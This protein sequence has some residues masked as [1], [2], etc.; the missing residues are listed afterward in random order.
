MF[1]STDISVTLWI[2][3]RNKKE[4]TFEVNDGIK[5]YRS[6][7]GEVL[8]IDLRR[9]G[10]PYEKSYVEFIEEDVRKIA[11]NYHNWQQIDWKTTYQNIPE[12]CY[13]ANL[14]EIRN[15]NYSLTPS[16]YVE[17]VDRDLNLDFDIEMKR[18]QKKFKNIIQEE[19]ESQNELI[20]AFKILGYEI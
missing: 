2:L 1:Y 8:F 11:D 12:Y 6:R 9:W 5:N 4:R 16:K 15:N 18:I 17:F 19:K 7:E 13:S 3:N 14:E 10:T 20:N